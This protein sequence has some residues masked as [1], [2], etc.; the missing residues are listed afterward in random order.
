MFETTP[1]Q[2]DEILTA[3]KKVQQLEGALEFIRKYYPQMWDRVE[4]KDIAKLIELS[5]ICFI[6]SPELLAAT[7]NPKL[8]PTQ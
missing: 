2:E 4:E 1:D 6:S 3:V 5:H 7:T 8:L